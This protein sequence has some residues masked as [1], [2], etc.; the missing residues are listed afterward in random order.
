MVRKKYVNFAEI[1]RAETEMAT[2]GKALTLIECALQFGAGA[3]RGKAKSN[4]IV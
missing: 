4:A 1:Q 2:S 3:R